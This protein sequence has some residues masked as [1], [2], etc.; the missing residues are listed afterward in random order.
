VQCAQPVP[1]RIIRDGSELSR[2]MMRYGA[3]VRTNRTAEVKRID[4][5]DFEEA[6][7]TSQKTP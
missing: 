1:Q 5:D 2:L 3:S 6:E 4:L 7:V